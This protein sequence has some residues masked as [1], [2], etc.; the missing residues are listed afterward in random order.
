MRQNDRQTLV[1]QRPG[2]QPCQ[3]TDYGTWRGYPREQ[4]PWYPSISAEL[5]D[6]CGECVK[7]C[8]FGVYQAAPEGPTTVAE[9]YKCQVGCSMCTDICP[10]KAITFPPLSILDPFRPPRK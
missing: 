5:C 6:G 10:T 4:I 8:T 2:S 1:E 7:F 3:R 9:G